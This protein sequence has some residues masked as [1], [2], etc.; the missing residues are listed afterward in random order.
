MNLAQGDERPRLLTADGPEFQ[1]ERCSIAC[2]DVA[3][4]LLGKSEIESTSPVRAGKPAGS[5]T[6]TMN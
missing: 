2:D 1:Q 5:C 4:V 6:E 3:L